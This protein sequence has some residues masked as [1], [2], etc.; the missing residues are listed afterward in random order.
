MATTSNKQGLKELTNQELLD[1]EH[2]HQVHLDYLTGDRA[3]SNTRQIRRKIT[4]LEANLKKI[5]NEI[6]RRGLRED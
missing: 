4:S 2:N 6:E 5:G 1:M 3:P